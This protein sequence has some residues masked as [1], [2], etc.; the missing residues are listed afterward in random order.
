MEPR[1]SRRGS[2]EDYRYVRGA[3]DLGLSG[4]GAGTIRLVSHNG[5]PVQATLGGRGLDGFPVALDEQKFEIS[6]YPYGRIQ[7]VDGGG[8]HEGQFDDWHI[9]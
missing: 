6:L 5:G 7:L 4:T 3:R 8:T 1:R 9:I 2:A